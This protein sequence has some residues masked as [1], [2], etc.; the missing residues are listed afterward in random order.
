MQEHVH[1]C[2]KEN[3][4]TASSFESCSRRKRQSAWT[5]FG[6]LESGREGSGSADSCGQRG[7]HWRNETKRKT[8]AE[9]CSGRVA[10]GGGGA[11]VEE[12]ERGRLPDLPQAPQQVARLRARG[13]P[14]DVQ[15]SVRGRPKHLP[16][17]THTGRGAPRAPGTSSR[18][19]WPPPAPACGTGTPART[20]GRSPGRRGG[21]GRRR[22]GGGRST[23][24]A[25]AG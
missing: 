2:V 16:R 17:E 10:C 11:H 25:P 19:R 22:G 20:A 13:R 8:S 1:I 5:R 9:G 12:P 7:C 4:R 6:M 15:R 23:A 21:R 18:R 3:A 24:P 14:V